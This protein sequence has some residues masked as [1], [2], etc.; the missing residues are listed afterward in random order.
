MI[1]FTPPGAG[2]PSSGDGQDRPISLA[3][4]GLRAGAAS[5]L[6]P[7]PR[8]K[9][10]FVLRRC[11]STA[12]IG[13]SAAFASVAHAGTVTTWYGDANGFG[14]VPAV[15][16]GDPFLFSDLPGAATNADTDAWIARDDVVL[17][18]GG[19]SA[20]LN[21]SWTGQLLGASLEVFSGGW[22]MSGAASLYVNGSFVGNVSNGT[23]ANDPFNVAVMDVFDLSNVLNGLTGADQIEIRPADDYD[24]GVVD[25]LKLTLSVQDPA[26]NTVPEPASLALASIAVAGVL[27]T[28]RRRLD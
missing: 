8:M 22:G 1:V 10:N 28:R 7:D 23:T 15:A 16:S 18:Q 27:A 24:G 14:L 9:T 5:S 26:G 19:F 21:S 20:V 2:A 12:L 3:S 25:Y 11:L 6:F 13:L 17:L 4:A